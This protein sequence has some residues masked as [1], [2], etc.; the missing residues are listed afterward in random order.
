MTLAKRTKLAYPAGAQE[1][2]AK[3]RERR[4]LRNRGT[5]EDFFYRRGAQCAPI[6]LPLRSARYFAAAQA[7]SSPQARHKVNARRV[8]EGSQGITVLRN[9]IACCYGWHLRIYLYEY[10]LSDILYPLS[11]LKNACFL[12]PNSYLAETEDFSYNEI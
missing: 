1:G 10:A 8:R 2:M 5:A 11:S 6:S 9:S 12:T 4:P 7:A 3:I